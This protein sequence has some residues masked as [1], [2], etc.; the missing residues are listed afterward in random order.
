MKK[1][2]YLIVILLGMGILCLGV[3]M[4]SEMFDATKSTMT[5]DGFLHEPLFFLIPIGYVF[6][7]AG[8]LAAGFKLIM[9]ARQRNNS[10]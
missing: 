9:K 1:L 3:K 10:L 7:F 6:I 8:I 4:G 5:K 2:N